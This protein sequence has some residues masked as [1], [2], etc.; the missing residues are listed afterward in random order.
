MSVWI[1]ASLPFYFCAIVCAVI[2]VACV[3][4]RGPRETASDL[5][6]QFLMYLLLSGV[7]MA[8]AARLST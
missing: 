2:A 5:C 6:F 4:Y 7:F 1:L 8:M 3:A